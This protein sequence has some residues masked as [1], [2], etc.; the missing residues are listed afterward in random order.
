[1]FPD[2][3]SHFG[4]A[5]ILGLLR[6]PFIPVLAIAAAKE[7]LDML[8]MGTPS[9]DDFLWSFFGA[10]IGCY[11]SPFYYDVRNKEV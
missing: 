7:A 2:H 4:C 8:G 9:L 10:L 1:M 11:D 3:I 6:I 5:A